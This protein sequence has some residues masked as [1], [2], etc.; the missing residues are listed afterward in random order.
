MLAYQSTGSGSDVVLLHGWG[1]TSASVW[2]TNG[3]F[4]QLEDKGFR[5]T[6]ID[7]PGHGV[8]RRSHDAADYADLASAVARQL[9]L[10]GKM[11]GIGYSLGAK[12][13]LELAARTPQ[14]FAAL[15]LAGVGANAFAPEQS[16]PVVAEVLEN[17]VNATTPEPVRSLVAYGVRAGNDALALAACLRRSANPVLDAARLSAIDCPALVIVGDRDTLA[18][19]LAPLVEALPCGASAVLAGVSHLGLPASAQC[20]DAVLTFLTELG[21][22]GA[23]SA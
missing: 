17:G 9:P 7:L 2:K 11:I 3:W 12:I 5:I 14:R 18:L 4:D 8:A 1:G 16:G 19:P 21:A 15:V 22:P 10:T 6:S 23:V 13:M 20:R